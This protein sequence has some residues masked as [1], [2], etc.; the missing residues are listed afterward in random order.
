[1]KYYKVL[2]RLKNGWRKSAG[3]I[4]ETFK[5]TYRIGKTTRSPFRKGKLFIFRTLKAAKDYV[6]GFHG[7]ERVGMEIWEVDAENPK[8]IRCAAPLWMESWKAGFVSYQRE[9]VQSFWLGVSK[10]ETATTH[11]NAYSA[12]SVRLIAKVG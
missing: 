10:A 2:R 11:A 9:K 3:D 5:I 6:L 4:P 12:D 1:M 7:L 8:T